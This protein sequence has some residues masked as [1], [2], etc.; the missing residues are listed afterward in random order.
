MLCHPP[1]VCYS[2]R[3]LSGITRQEY[4]S[5]LNNS[6]HFCQ[7]KNNFSSKELWRKLWINLLTHAVFPRYFLFSKFKTVKGWNVEGNIGWSLRQLIKPFNFQSYTASDG[8][9]RHVRDRWAGADLSRNDWGLFRELSC[10]SPW[11][12]KENHKKNQGE[13]SQ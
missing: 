6:F 8:A 7:M 13:E 2:C 11:L 12:T 3:T 1:A 5:K 4:F 9:R 10:H